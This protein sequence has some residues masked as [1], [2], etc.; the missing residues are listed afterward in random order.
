PILI[1]AAG[2]QADILLKFCKSSGLYRRAIGVDGAPTG[3]AG[4]EVAR[5]Y[6]QCF[7]ILGLS[8]WN[9]LSPSAR[10]EAAIE[11]CWQALSTTLTDPQTGLL[12][13]DDTVTD[14]A[15]PDAPPRSQNP[16]MHLY[17]ACL[18]SYE[19]TGNA[20]WLERAT[21]LRNLSLRHFFDDDTDSLAEFISP[22]LS[23][24]AG[25]TG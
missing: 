25:L 24:L 20:L 2:R 22:D 5:S 6:D 21:H 9:R 14:P 17:E 8:T 7:V 16:H 15:A 1:R 19:M 13:E 4:D 18:Q 11:D 3:N 23:A 10:Q 12:L